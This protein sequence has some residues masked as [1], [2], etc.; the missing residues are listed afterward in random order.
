MAICSCGGPKEEGFLGRSAVAA[1]LKG[2]V[3]RIETG[4]AQLKI[5]DVDLDVIQVRLPNTYTEVGSPA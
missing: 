1:P 3:G 4:E 2:V 5:V